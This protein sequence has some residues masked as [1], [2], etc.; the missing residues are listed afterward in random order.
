M[1]IGDAYTSDPS[2]DPVEAGAVTFDDKYALGDA[3]FNGTINIIDLIRIKKYSLE[4]DFDGST[5]LDIIDLDE[6]VSFGATD[7]TAL[8]KMLIESA[9]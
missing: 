2:G 4:A 1:V 6:S 7:V 9:A 5:I 3:D 8:R